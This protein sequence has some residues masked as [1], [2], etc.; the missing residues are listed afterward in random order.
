MASLN[1][2]QSLKK[3]G[4]TES[5][6]ATNRKFEGLKTYMKK[7]LFILTALLVACTASF[8]QSKPKSPTAKPAKTHYIKGHIEGLSNVDVYLA[9]YYGNK[10]FYNDTAHVDEKGF[11]EFKGKPFNECG[12]YALVM[13]G[14]RY[15][16]FIATEENL[17]LNCSA[18]A[19]LA[20]IQVEKNLD[21]ELFFEYIRYINKKKTERTPMDICLADSTKAEADKAPCREALTKLND[22]VIAYQKKL[23][24]EHPNTLFAKMLNMSMEQEVPVAPAGMTEEKAREW[25]YYQYRAHYWDRCDLKDPRLVRDAGFHKLVEDFITKTLPQIPDTVCTEVK[26]L[27]D[28]TAGNED[29]FKYIVH[30]ATYTGETS[31]IMCMDELFVFMMDN[32]YSKGLCSW[33]EPKKLKEMQEAADKK[34]DCRCGEIAQDVILPDTT[35]KNWVSMYKSRGEYTLLV[36]WESSCGH[37][38]KEIP[39]LLDLYHKYKSKNFVVYAIGNDYENDKWIEFVNDKK[40]DWINVSDTPQIMKQEEASKLIYGGVTTLKSLNFRTTWDVTSTP[41]IYLMDKDM[42]IIAKGLGAEQLDELLEKLYKGGAVDS[43][44]IKNTEFEDINTPHK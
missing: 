10:L 22:E 17:I 38:K 7:S 28:K 31:K 19:D 6:S 11:Y 35:E 18:D 3:A 29:A 24:A 33:V 41:K 40:L 13:P 12:K 9:N 34:R 2:E 23:I 21:N 30:F 27:V 20:K 5:I 32:Y 25:Q 26:K 4:G 8:A 37:C 44:D 14:P 42:K 15:F 1:L 39:L 43:Q 36:I 16:D